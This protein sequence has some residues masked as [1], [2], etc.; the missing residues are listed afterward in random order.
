ML[1]A[2]ITLLLWNTGTLLVIGAL[3]WVITWALFFDRHWKRPR[4][5]SCWHDMSGATSLRCSE[6]GHVAANERRLHR[7]RRHWWLALLA[8][9]ALLSLTFY[10]R[11]EW[12]RRGW[13]EMVPDRVAVALLPWISMSGFSGDIHLELSDRVA[14]GHLSV[15]N[16]MR[17]LERV[18]EGDE[19]A[20]PGSV[21]WYEKYGRLLD[22]WVNSG[23]AAMVLSHGS[24]EPFAEIEKRLERLPP[25]LAIIPPGGWIPG[26]PVPMEL[27]VQRSI[28]GLPKKR[29]VIEGHTLSPVSGAPRAP[30]DRPIELMSEQP[31]VVR[32]PFLMDPLPEGTNFGEVT[33]R[34]EEGIGQGEWVPLIS[35][36]LPVSVR[37]LP[38][39]P[40]PPNTPDDPA[41]F[42]GRRS[43]ELDQAV[44]TF[45]SPG[46]VR[47]ERGDR[48]F[49]M[50]F[51][52]MH[53][54][55]SGFEDIAVG[56][57]AEILEDGVVRRRLLVWWSGARGLRFEPPEEDAE[58]LER[59][60]A[61]DGRWTLRF[62]GLRSVALRASLGPGGTNRTAWWDG[63]V[64]VPL[65]V[66]DVAFE[67]I[68]RMWSI[69]STPIGDDP[70]AQEPS[71]TT[72]APLR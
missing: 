37:V 24:V 64:T 72:A 55:T 49:A 21:A 23:R 34:V 70:A 51:D 50:R 53:L 63:E 6:C 40:L 22:R 47:W 26:L 13:G 8:F 54:L 38:R 25:V 18:A 33:V 3:V 7:R 31:F 15:P 9:A 20:R 36:E 61:E 5:P 29:L 67:S 30:M 46:L 39:W 65:R 14:R 58:A 11:S 56:G 19:A 57:V 17:L 2:P 1:P 27:M 66:Q 48:R 35:L 28:G 44:A 52:P 12:S 45:V 59:A 43:P 60:N 16:A 4:C 68:P 41:E 62:R 42:Q 71:D 10:L 69:G 32:I